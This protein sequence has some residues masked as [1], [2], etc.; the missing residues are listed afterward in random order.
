ME[1]QLAT[2]ADAKE[3][4]QVADKVWRETYIPINGVDS[5]NYMLKK[6][7]SAEV[8]A[9]QISTGAYTYWLAEVDGHIVGYLAYQVREADIFLSKVYLLD[10]ARGHG[11]ATQLLGKIP[12]GKKITL[13]V[14]KNNVVAQARYKKWGFQVVDAV[15]TDIGGGFVMDDFI[16]QKEN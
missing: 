3:L 13:T 9:E 10:S 6:F 7:Q 4:A 8:M 2:V 14:N 5:V 12:T 1:I 15:V 11:V 16:M